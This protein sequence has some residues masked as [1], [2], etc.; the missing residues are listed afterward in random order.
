[1]M[2]RAERYIYSRDKNKTVEGDFVNDVIF[3]IIYGML[4]NFF[5]RHNTHIYIVRIYTVCTLKQ[6]NISY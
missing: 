2:I 5:C 1:M 6:A 3:S 4:L